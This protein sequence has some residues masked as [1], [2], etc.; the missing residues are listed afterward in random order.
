MY[1]SV[2]GSPSRN[3]ATD[4]LAFAT[5]TSYATKNGYKLIRN[6]IRMRRQDHANAD[7][8][9]RWFPFEQ[10]HPAA[11]LERGRGGGGVAGTPQA[12]GRLGVQEFHTCRRN[13]SPPAATDCGSGTGGK[14]QQGRPHANHCRMFLCRDG[15]TLNVISF[16]FPR[17][18][19][20][21]QKNCVHFLVPFPLPI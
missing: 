21:P 18:P 4:P 2:Q 17:F 3:A 10:G 9:A 1:K 20:Y 11:A 12:E 19:K 16:L 5:A 7:S 13:Q 14:R 15:F 8:G 6:R